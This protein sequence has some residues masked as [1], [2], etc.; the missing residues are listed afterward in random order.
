MKTLILVTLLGVGITAAAQDRDNRQY[1]DSRNYNAQGVPDRIN[2]SFR[3]D[4]PDARDAQ[5]EHNGKSWHATYHG[6]RDRN[7]DAYYDR[8]GRMIDQ[9]IAWDNSQLPGDFDNNI[10]NRYHTHD[11]KVYRIERPN[12]SPLFQLSLNLGG[13]STTIYTDENGNRV[14]YKDRH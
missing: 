11:Y 8:R 5:W 9:H 3:H 4:H 10:Y 2:S 12:A 14:R 13:G 7:V 1:N 6:D